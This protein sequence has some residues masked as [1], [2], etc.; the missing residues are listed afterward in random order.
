MKKLMTAFAVCLLAGIVSA[1]EGITSLNIV[2]YTTATAPNE[3]W[4][5]QATPFVQI[6]GGL[7]AG[8]ND[9]FTGNFTDGDELYIWDVSIQ[10]YVSLIWTTDAQDEAYE[11]VIGTG[12]A[13]AGVYS[14]VQVSVGQGAF[15]HAL[16][17]AVN[18]VTAGEVGSGVTLTIPSGVW[19]MVSLPYPVATLVNDPTWTGF[20]DGDE[21]YIWDSSIQDY[22]S[23]IWTT[24][25]QDEAYENVIGTGWANAGV[26]S[27]VPLNIGGAA[28][29]QKYSAGDG[30]LAY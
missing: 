21:I 26:Y 2:G 8:V 30:S 12:W 5:M 19:S 6:G 18:V 9:V 22:V 3:A 13:N 7:L 29:I 10:D 15:I 20:A 11:N 14:T 17:G 23:L 16:A 24:D 1:A 28:F 27:Y 25:A 4:V